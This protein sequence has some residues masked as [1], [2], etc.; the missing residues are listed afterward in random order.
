MLHTLISCN[1]SL[2]L[3]S[4]LSQKLYKYEARAKEKSQRPIKFL[5]VDMSPV[6]HI[7]STALHI[8]S[9]LQADYEARGIA[10]YLSNPSCIVMEQ[11]ELSGLADQIGRDNIYVG[12]HDAVNSCLRSLTDEEA[13]AGGEEA[14]D[15][16]AGDASNEQVEVIME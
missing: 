3:R 15:R 13:N 6:S 14:D 8:L 7:D 9:D 4:F 12:V 16:V 2:F 1:L 10:L 11:L 5:V